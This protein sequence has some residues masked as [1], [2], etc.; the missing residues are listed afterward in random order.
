M[1]ESSTTLLK[2][3]LKKYFNRK[4]AFLLPNILCYIR[5]L[6]MVLF[7]ISYILSPTIGDNRFAYVY[8]SCGIM[9]LAEYTDFLE[10]LGYKLSFYKADF[11]SDGLRFSTSTEFS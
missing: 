5:V 2:G 10:S 7:T 9:A 4:D 8:L 1:E 6:L 3:V 11:Y